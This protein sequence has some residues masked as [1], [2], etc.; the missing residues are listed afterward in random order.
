MPQQTL[1]S[2]ALKKFVSDTEPFKVVK[3]AGDGNATIYLYK[4]DDIMPKI[5]TELAK[6]QPKQIISYLNQTLSGNW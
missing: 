4:K 1:Q 5:F 2:K 6:K 3:Y